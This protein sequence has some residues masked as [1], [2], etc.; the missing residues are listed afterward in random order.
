MANAGRVLIMPKGD[1][2]TSTTYEMLDLVSHNG[3]S[4]LAKKQTKGNEPSDSNS[5]YW[6]KMV[7]ES[8]GGSSGIMKDH[9]FDE[10]NPHNVTAEQ[11]GL[12]KVDN[13]ADSEKKVKYA[14]SAGSVAWDNVSN[15]PSSYTP[16]SHTHSGVDVHVTALNLGTGSVSTAKPYTLAMALSDIASAVSGAYSSLSGKANSSHGNH[17]PTTQSANNKVFLRND[18]T[19][20]TITP[21]NIGAAASSHGNHVPTTQTASNKV[22][23]RNDNTWQTVTPANIGAAASSHSHSYLPLSGGTMSG[24]IILNNAIALK[25]KNT[26]GGD[27]GLIGINSS[28]NLHINNGTNKVDMYLHNASQQLNFSASYFGSNTSKGVTLGTS[29]KLWGQIYSSN[30]SISTSDRNEK[31]N[32]TGLTDVHKKFFMKLMPVS[33]TFKDGTSGRTH[34]GFISQDVEDAMEELG[35]TSL[36][37]A[38][39]CKDVKK[40]D[41][42]DE[43][44]DIYYEEDVLDEDGNQVYIYSLRYEEFIGI[45]A[46]VLQDSVHRLNAIEERLAKAGI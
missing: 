10:N 19:W 38:G 33:F 32:I 5:E 42:L 37:F 40:K 45:I 7:S 44:G 30:A 13:S 31:D 24:S 26:S 39:F 27:V 34:I 11:I 12:E 2:D 35:M 21:A 41:V 6:H 20:Q 43:N 15:K 17:V 14:D 36:D 18:N 25:T 28:N 16:S 1:Y 23:L 29:S 3:T 9:I 46:Y 8:T 4:W 22:F